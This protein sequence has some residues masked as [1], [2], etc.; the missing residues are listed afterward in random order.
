MALPEPQLPIDGDLAPSALQALAGLFIGRQAGG[1]LQHPRTS[2]DIV[3]IYWPS[4][5]LPTF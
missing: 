2:I 5:F 1:G 4:A 3:R